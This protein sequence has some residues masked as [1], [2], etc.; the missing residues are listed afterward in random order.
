MNGSPTTIRITGLYGWP[1]VTQRVHTWNLIRNLHSQYQL[2]WFIGGDYNE[3]L[4][5]SEKV[6][7]CDRIHTQMEA[8]QKT[9]SECALMDI[10]F[11]GSQYTWSNKRATPHTVRC[12]LDRV[13]VNDQGFQLFP[14]PEV[15]HLPLLGSDHC[16]I[17]LS[18]KPHGVT[19][20][21]RAGRPF[22]FE[23]FWVSKEECQDIICDTWKLM[24]GTDNWEAW[25][26]RGESCRDRL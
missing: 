8:F 4:H 19:N 7:G 9:L 2:P 1:E 26:H 21:F 24:G 12:R 10:G 25:T 5:R 11:K 17:L 3:I 16:P 22:R 6:G 14:N 15:Q 23:S 20:R 18:L 13:C